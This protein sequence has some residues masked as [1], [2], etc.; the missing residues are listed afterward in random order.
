VSAV[1]NRWLKK[2]RKE[3]NKDEQVIEV[4]KRKK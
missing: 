3:T 4:K 2:E 1:P